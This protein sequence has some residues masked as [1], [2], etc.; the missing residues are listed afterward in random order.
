M[1]A[2]DIMLQQCETQAEKLCF[3]KIDDNYTNEIDIFN[4]YFS[5]LKQIIE[6]DK[7]CQAEKKVSKLTK[8]LKDFI[9]RI[10]NEQAE[11]KKKINNLNKNRSMVCYGA[12]KYQFAHRIN[13]R[14]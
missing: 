10:E 3:I 8:L 4:N 9:K 5:Q 1:S 14:F 11:K 7:S 13:R 2:F 12:V 6:H